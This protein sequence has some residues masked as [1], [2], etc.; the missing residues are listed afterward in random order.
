ME[1]VWESYI[2]LKFRQKYVVIQRNSKKVKQS[3]ARSMLC[4]GEWSHE[5]CVNLWRTRGNR[6]EYVVYTF[7]RDGSLRR[8]LSLAMARFRTDGQER[9]SGVLAH[10]VRREDQEVFPENDYCKFVLTYVIRRLSYGI[11]WGIY[12]PV[13]M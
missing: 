8:D 3:N 7:G 13:I 2:N 1:F 12:Y 6:I 9:G 5:T 4:G 11:S 10:T